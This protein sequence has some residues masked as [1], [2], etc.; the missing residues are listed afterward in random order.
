MVAG[1]RVLLL[2]EPNLPSKR[3]TELPYLHSFYSHFCIYFYIFATGK[4]TAV[5]PQSPA[6]ARCEMYTSSLAHAT[7]YMGLHGK[8]VDELF[9]YFQVNV[10]AFIQGRAVRI[11]R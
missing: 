6:A 2:L 4:V 8:I 11:H 9:I 5:L 10:L 3:L 1:K 7:E